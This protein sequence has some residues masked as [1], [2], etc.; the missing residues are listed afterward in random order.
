MKT[1]FIIV[2]S[3]LTVVCTLPYILDV[4]KRKTKPREVTWLNWSLLAALAASASLSDHQYAAAALSFCGTIETL[5]VFVLGWRYGDK[6]IARFDIACQTAAIIGLALW[7]IFN[8]PAIAVLASITIDFIATLPT[9]RHS[10]QKPTEETWITFF[11][12]GIAAGFTVAAAK[13]ARITSLANPIYLVA[14][15]LLLAG[16]IIYRHPSIKF[17]YGAGNA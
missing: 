8:S 11:L 3:L 4:I 2:S 9:I 15:N 5:A 7:F 1:V 14:I 6:S 10:W 17:R 16:I 12:A 13:E